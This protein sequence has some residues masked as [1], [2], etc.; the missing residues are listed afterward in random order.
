VGNQGEEVIK[1]LNMLINVFS[2][3]LHWH[4][5]ISAKLLLQLFHLSTC[6]YACNLRIP[7][8]SFMKIDTG[9]FYKQ[10]L[11]QIPVF[12][13]VM[14]HFCTSSSPD[15]ETLWCLHRCEGWTCGLI[16]LEDE[17]NMILWN[18]TNHSASDTVLHPTNFTSSSSP[19]K[20][21]QNL[22]L[23]SHHVSTRSGI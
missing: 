2:Y 4:M 5:Q 12:W 6:L 11:G 13:D 10:L 16:T 17:W 18:V 3:P 8:Q 21:P 20:E 14:R 9:E 19:P 23:L 7:R 22:K 15:S 1:S